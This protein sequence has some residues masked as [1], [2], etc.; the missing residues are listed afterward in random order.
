MPHSHGAPGDDRGDAH[1]EAEPDFDL[2]E[3]SFVEG[4]WAASDPTSFLRL[5]GVPFHGRDDQGRGLA[6]VRVEQDQA[7][8][9]AA[10]TPQ[11]DGQGVRT[12][13]LP[14]AR[15]GRRR[16]L[17]LVYLHGTEPRHL[18]LAEAR[19]LSSN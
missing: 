14:A 19:A 15:V 7:A 5:A 10:V 9:V 1:A 17:R 2:V 4:F 12:D 3:A 18:T 8:D 16:R 11:L 13:P 6:L